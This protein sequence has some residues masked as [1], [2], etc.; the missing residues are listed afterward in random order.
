MKAGIKKGRRAAR[1]KRPKQ[2]LPGIV[3]PRM[4]GLDSHG[5]RQLLG[6]F[7]QTEKWPPKQLATAQFRQ[8][9]TLLR[10][11]R[12]TVPFYREHLAGF[13]L[14][15]ADLKLDHWRQIPLLTRRVLQ[16]KGDALLSEKPPPEHGKGGKVTTSGS[17]GMPDDVA[18][19]HGARSPVASS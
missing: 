6:V 10:H 17:T 11:A 16:D 9:R 8:L 19:T 5:V 7:A 13:D 1:P 12:E 15:G 14:D 3:W 18:G 4:R 2:D